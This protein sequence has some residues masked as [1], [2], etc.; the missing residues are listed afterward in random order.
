MKR[1]TVF[2][3]T[4]LLLGLTSVASAWQG[5]DTKLP[6]PSQT[7]SSSNAPIVVARPDGAQLSLPKGFSIDTYAEGFEKP[8][9]MALGPSGEVLVSDSVE[10]GSVYVLQDRDKDFK[11]ESRQ[12]LIGNLNRPY[13]LAFWKNFLYVAEPTSVKR[14]QYD[15]KAMKVAEPGQEVVSMKDFAKGH[16]TRTVLFDLKGQK[17]YLAIGSGS[18]V[19]AGDDSKRAAI[20]RYNPDGTGHEIVASGLRNPIGLR[21]YPGTNTLWTTVCGLC[22][23][24]TRRS[25]SCRSRSITMSVRVTS[26]KAAPG[27]LICLSI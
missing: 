5:K 2:Q 18:N 25:L 8:R 10:N 24:T 27:L 17:M 9:F 16:W 11:S 13:G 20:N 19:D 21:W 1:L 3:L 23:I 6:A 4:A 26:A 15:S 22:S 7:V 12:K 14:Y